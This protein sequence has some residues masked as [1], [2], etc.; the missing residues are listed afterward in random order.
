MNCWTPGRH[1]ADAL[2]PGGRD[3]VALAERAAE[4]GALQRVGRALQPQVLLRGREDDARRGLRFGLAHLDEIARSD[5]GIGALEPVDAQDVEPLVLGIGHRPRARASIACRRSRSR[6]PRR[7][8]APPSACAAYAPG[9]G[10][11]L[12]PRCSPPGSCACRR[13]AVG[14]LVLLQPV[15]ARKMG[16]SAVAA[17]RDLRRTKKGPIPKDRP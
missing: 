1:V 9:R 11:I 5:A 17:W 2:L 15:E 8:P 3:D 4:E 16:R 10:R 6:R 7:C 12:G 14:H 13:L